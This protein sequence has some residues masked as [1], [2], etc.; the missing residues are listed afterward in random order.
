MMT[1]AKE[2]SV[3]RPEGLR[4]LLEEGGGEDLTDDERALLLALIGADAEIGRSLSEEEL[5]ALE[6][7]REQVEG[8]DA[9]ELAQAIKHMVRSQSREGRRLKWP[10]L[11]WG[12]RKR[13][14]SGE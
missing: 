4:R 12:H 14:S 9:E 8:Y 13:R 11:K 2:E 7:L 3:L 10:E 5:A 6:K 1:K